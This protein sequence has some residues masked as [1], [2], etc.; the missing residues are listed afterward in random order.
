LAIQLA[1]Q[2]GLTLAGFVRNRNLVI[3]S[4]AERLI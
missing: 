1:Q 3:Y 4:H 2:S